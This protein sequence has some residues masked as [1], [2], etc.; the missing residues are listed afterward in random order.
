MKAKWNLFW[1]DYAEL[2]AAS[3]RFWKSI[4]LEPWCI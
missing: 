4:G 3:N 2:F 1:E